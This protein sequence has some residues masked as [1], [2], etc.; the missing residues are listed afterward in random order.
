MPGWLEKLWY[1]APASHCL[2]RLLSPLQALFGWLAR[3]R[4]QAYV[5]G[6]KTT[7]RSPL[8]VVVVGNITVGGTGKTPVTRWLVEQLCAQGWH[9]VILSRGYGGRAAHYPMQIDQTSRP[10]EAGDEPCMLAQSLKVPILVDP[11]RA[12]AARYAAQHALGDLLICDDG[13][14]HAALARDIEILVLDG[15][16]GV[17][18]G[19]LLPA[20]PLREPAGRMQQVD[21]VICNG[22]AQHP[23]IPKDAWPMQ[24]QPMTLEN[25]RTGECVSLH[26]LAGRPIHAVAAIGHP[27]RFFASLRALDAQ[28]VEHPFADHHPFQPG[29]LPWSDLPLVMTEKDAVKCRSWA[30]ADWWFLRV[31]AQ[32]PAALLHQLCQRLADLGY[33]P[34]EV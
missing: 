18:N 16:R 5:T 28:L 14:Q 12:R 29:D 21:A 26:W 33:H 11:L 27:A 2:A 6:K 25:L 3:R 7:Y 15:M 30:G 13:L 20:G 23:A 24:L 22:A 10:E 32:L 19:R 31:S 17:G 4:R 1:Q 9:P 8:P 34:H